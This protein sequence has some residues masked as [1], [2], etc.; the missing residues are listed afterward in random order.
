MRG[1]GRLQIGRKTH[2]IDPPQIFVFSPGDRVL[3]AHDPLDPLEVYA[4]HFTVSP[5][6]PRAARGLARLQARRLHDAGFV[7]DLMDRW[8]DW[9]DSAGGMNDQTDS[10]WAGLLLG[11]LWRGAHLGAAHVAE[12]GLARLVRDIRKRPQHPWT[13]DEMCAAASVSATVLNERFRRVTGLPPM[14]FVIRQRVQRACT[15]LE[16]SRMT[17]EQ[18]AEA[19]GY[20]DVFFFSR[21]FRQLQ[22][23]PPGAYRKSRYTADA[24]SRETGIRSRPEA[25]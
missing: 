5:D 10:W 11:H 3:G 4:F 13:L 24:G 18:I 21:Q 9:R 17:I 20:R 16:E 14:K 2:A 23:A 15:L 7:T 8:I 25:R 6:G 19:A 1:R 22:G 12:D